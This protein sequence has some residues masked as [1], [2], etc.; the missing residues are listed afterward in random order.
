MLDRVPLDCDDI[1]IRVLRTSE[2]TET[3]LNPLWER[4]FSCL[5]PHANQIHRGQHHGQVEQDVEQGAARKAEA[6]QQV[7]HRRDEQHNQQQ[8]YVGGQQT[9]AQGVLHGGTL[10]RGPEL[11][12][13][14]AQQ[15]QYR[16]QQKSRHQ[17]AP[18]G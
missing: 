12:R 1:T 3:E 5:V 16:Q 13:Q 11:E 7:G 15:H 8:G 10:K 4:V 6:G 14:A 17:C 2:G 18:I 9:D